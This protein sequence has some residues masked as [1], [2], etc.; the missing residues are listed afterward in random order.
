MFG[1]LMAASMRFP[2]AVFAREPFSLKDAYESAV[3]YDAQLLGA[4]ADRAISKEE[5]KKAKSAFLPN[6]RASSSRGRNRTES[7][8]PYSHNYGQYYSTLSSSLSLKQPLFNMGSIAMYKQAKAEEA[9]SESLFRNEHF[10]LIVRT[11]ELFCN[12]LYSEENIE[13]TR[14]QTKAAQEQLEQSKRKYRNGFGTIT[15]ISESQAS[16]DMSVADEANSIAILEYN[17][18]ELERVTGVYAETLYRLQPQKLLLT[19]PEPR[20]IEAWVA[21]AREN[22]SKVSAARKE[23]EIARREVDK[24]RASRYPVVDLWAGRSYS[25]SEDNYTIGSTYNTYSFSVQVSVPIYTG[26]YTSALIRQSKVRQIKAN[27]ELNQQERAVL[28]DVRKFFNG[29]LNSIAQVKAYEQAVRSNEIAVE[30]TKKGFLAGFRSNVDVL[31]A[32]KKLLESRRSLAKARYEY[33][34]DRLMLKESAG[35]LTPEDIDEVNTYFV[36]SRP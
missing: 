24:S 19:A 34:L 29:Q 6:V 28:S 3:H 2:S 36:A 7:I 5:V 4:D 30:G 31:E 26:G 33:I 15:E 13:F 20:N 21:M 9:K 22:N 23:I 18:R 10:S 35:I 25:M 16:Y 17:R 8:T 14:A 27:E 32:Q 12:V 1:L 11:A